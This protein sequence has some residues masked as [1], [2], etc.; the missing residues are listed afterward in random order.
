[1]VNSKAK[2]SAGE[3][4]LANRLKALGLSARRTQ[5]Y[6]GMAGDSDV[7]CADLPKYHIECKRVERLNIDDAMSQAVRD[8]HEKTPICAHRRNGKPWL[9]TMFLE[10]W[11]S[12]V[13]PSSPL[14]ESAETQAKDPLWPR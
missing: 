14:D 10:D 4:E 5:Q 2:G 7:E 12:L 1:M 6:C 8:C 13:R 3:R 11:V 9:V